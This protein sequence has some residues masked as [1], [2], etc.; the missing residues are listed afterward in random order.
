[1]SHEIR[2]PL[3]AILGF[4]DM[5]KDPELPVSLRV[6]HAETIKRSGKHLVEIINS[7][8][9][10]SKI[11]SGRMTVE[12]VACD[13]RTIVTEAVALL[14]PLAVHPPPLPLHV[15]QALAAAG[16]ALNHRQRPV[17]VEVELVNQAARDAA[18]ALPPLRIAVLGAGTFALAAWA[19]LLKYVC[20]SGEREMDQA[21]PRG[22]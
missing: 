16:D 2:T 14:Q 15:P 12:I 22:R 21:S 11:E 7:I 3:T 19:P 5:L 20:L 8:L 1:M 13:V 9:D 6:S 18:G 4:A 17:K 10:F